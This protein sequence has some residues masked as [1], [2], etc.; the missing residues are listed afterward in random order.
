MSLYST[1]LIRLYHFIAGKNILSRNLCRFIKG[2]H[3]LGLI[4]SLHRCRKI[5]FRFFL[6]LH[7]WQKFWPTKLNRFI[8]Y[9][10]Q[11]LCICIALNDTFLSIVAHHWSG[12]TSTQ[13]T[14]Y[15]GVVMGVLFSF[16]EADILF[17]DFN[18]APSQKQNIIVF[19]ANN[20]RCCECHVAPT[21]I[22]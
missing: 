6:S 2:I 14:W 19:E 7:R 15:G 13:G 10:S 5:L 18:S 1:K 21:I 12:V 20:R 8:R 9:F 3:K 11:K 16:N 17:R 22:L 4:L